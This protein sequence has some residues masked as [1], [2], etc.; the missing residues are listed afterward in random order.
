[1]EGITLTEK[2]SVIKSFNN[3]VV[4]V[5]Y[6]GVETILFAKGI[7][8]G[9][10]MGDV[11]PEN[12]VV[13]KIFNLQ[14]KQNAKNFTTIIQDVDNSIVGLI[15]EVIYFISHELGEELSENIHVSLTDHI[16]F[17]IKRLQRGEAIENPFLIET[18]T[19][20][21]DEYSIAKKAAEK[22][23]KE[24]DIKIPE[25]EIGFIALYIHSARHK[26]TL[27]STLQY[28]Y[29]FKDIL[30]LIEKDMH[31]K[32]DKKSLDYARF[33]THVRFTIERITKE[34][35]LNN[36]LLYIIKEKYP[37]A[38]NTAFKVGKLIER[39][40]KKTVSEDEVAYL[41]MHLERFKRN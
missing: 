15:E 9:K 38:F 18:E 4:L 29:I 22:L 2:S 27:S 11:I 3:N 34:I 31:V 20:Y 7:G 16:S 6:K 33:I 25:G 13:E 35:P 40:L 36:D 21:K 32:V 17:A 41:A 39:A 19:L 26:G 8:F 10:R 23:E 1:M 12:T 14:D 28:N 5:S 24:I 30:N 37:V